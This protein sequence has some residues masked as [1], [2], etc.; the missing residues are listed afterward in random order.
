MRHF[1]LLTVLLGILPG[2]T[3]AT[4]YYGSPGSYL[5]YIDQ[6]AGG[7]TLFLA[8]GVYTDRLNLDDITGEPGNPIV[9]TGPESGEAA[10]FNGNACCNTVSIERC[11]YL[12]I[13]HLTLDGQDIPFIDAVKAEGTNGNWAHDITIE[14]LTVIN[15]AEGDLIV[16]IN[17]KC[18]AWN[19]I[20]RFNTFI[21]PGLGMYL[22]APDGTAAFVN[23]IIEYNLVI[24]PRRYGIQVKHQIIGS[25]DVESMPENGVTYVRY[26][27]I[28]KAENSDPDDARPNLLVGAFP[29]SGKGSN[30]HYEIY[31]NLL[32]QNPDE[33]LF[34]GTGNYGFYN[35]ILVN[36]LDGWGIYAFPHNGFMPR[37]VKIFNNTILSKNQGIRLSGVNDSYTQII[38]G[39]AIFSDQP[40]YDTGVGT[41]YANV[42]DAFESADLYLVNP[43][44]DLATVDMT[45][46]EELH[47]GYIDPATFL[48]YQ[49]AH[50]DFDYE[51]RDWEYR[52]AYGS[53]GPPDWQLAPEIRPLPDTSTVS[54]LYPEFHPLT[55]YPNPARNGD[56][57]LL[58]GLPDDAFPGLLNVLSNDGR[59]V[60]KCTIHS[61]HPF[62]EIKSLVAGLYF[63]EYLSSK[64]LYRGTLVVVE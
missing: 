53:P 13:R 21:E 35:N 61:I 25:R 52:G 6:L 56:L 63:V 46:T 40:I 34:Q 20:I 18:P 48:D 49:D 27:V 41:Q 4:N 16:G 8:A 30:D 60:R 47:M 45:P 3:L 50:L 43:A 1:L 42:T 36:H 38:A 32:W 7:D 2:L 15:H 64:K 37:D 9:I 44:Q 11:A 26:N 59:I 29:E 31:G 51:M 23:G 24:N 28:S 33:G 22:G 55:L 12:V 62:L 10:V 39:N 19:W 14:Y 5:Q 58:D 57:L 54:I 17:T